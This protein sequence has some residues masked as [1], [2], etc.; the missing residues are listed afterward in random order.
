MIFGIQGQ[1]IARS[2]WTWIY[3]CPRNYCNV[4][5][6]T[7]LP[8]SCFSVSRN[9]LNYT[10]LSQRYASLLLQKV[11]KDSG[12]FL[13]NI[14]ADSLASINLEIASNTLDFR[15]IKQ[16]PL[17]NLSEDEAA[18]LLSLCGNQSCGK[19]TLKIRHA[20]KIFEGASRKTV[21]L[22]NHLL[23][24][25]I[26]NGKAFDSSILRSMKK[27]QLSPNAT[28]YAKLIG[29]HALQG[30]VD[31][32]QTIVDFARRHNMR[33]PDEIYGYIAYA[34][35]VSG[36]PN[37]GISMIDKFHEGGSSFSWDVSC[38]LLRGL[39][40]QPSSKLFETVLE[41][42]AASSETP[43][44][45]SHILDIFVN[46]SVNGNY[47]KIKPLLN[48]RK[49]SENEVGITRNTLVLNYSRTHSLNF[50]ECLLLPIESP[51]SGKN[52]LSTLFYT[53][54]L[55]CIYFS[56]WHDLVLDKIQKLSVVYPCTQVVHSL[57]FAVCQ[58][59]PW[60]LPEIL[61][62]LHDNDIHLEQSFKPPLDE[63]D[64][65]KMFWQ[66]VCL[67]QSVYS[68]QAEWTRWASRL[69]WVFA[70]EKNLKL[71][72]HNRITKHKKEMLANLKPQFSI[73]KIFMFFKAHGLYGW[74]F[75]D[76]QNFLQNRDAVNL[77]ETK[78]ASL[79]L[80]SDP[81]SDFLGD[82]V[83]NPGKL[84]A[85]SVSNL[86]T[87]FNF[88][89]S[90]KA[91]YIRRTS[92]LMF[93]KPYYLNNSIHSLSDRLIDLLYSSGSAKRCPILEMTARYLWLYSYILTP[94]C[95]LLFC[96]C[97]E[98]GRAA[99]ADKLLQ[100]LNFINVK[101]ETIPAFLLKSSNV[102]KLNV[103]KSYLEKRNSERSSLILLKSYVKAGMLTQACQVADT[104]SNM[105]LSKEDTHDLVLEF[106]QSENSVENVYNFVKCCHNIKAFNPEVFYL[107]A[108]R[109]FLDQN[110]FDEARTLALKFNSINEP[111]VVNLV[112]LS[113]FKSFQV[114]PQHVQPSHWKPCFQALEAE[115][116]DINEVL[117]HLRTANTIDKYLWIKPVF[118]SLCE[119]YRR[120]SVDDYDFVTEQVQSIFPSVQ[121]NRLSHILINQ[122]QKL[123]CDKGLNEAVQFACENL[124]ASSDENAATWSTV[125]RTCGDR[126]LA[127]N[128]SDLLHRLQDLTTTAVPK[129]KAIGDSY[130]LYCSM[131][132]SKS[133]ESLLELSADDLKQALPDLLELIGKNKD[134]K[135][136]N[137]LY[138]KLADRFQS[139]S[140]IHKTFCVSALLVNMHLKAVTNL[141]QEFLL[142]IA[143]ECYSATDDLAHLLR[144]DEYFR[145]L[146]F[147]DH[148]WHRHLNHYLFNRFSKTM[149]QTGVDDESLNYFV[150]MYHRIPSQDNTLFA[151]TVYLDLVTNVKYGCVAGNEL[152]VYH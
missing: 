133:F 63:N 78:I 120:I 101:I 46:L 65:P 36:F 111:A 134:E 13:S 67:A 71:K 119:L 70:I 76:L 19:R 102:E 81:K 79:R 80:I 103:V 132:Y 33:M 95:N 149:R 83:L 72:E 40:Q 26:E 22:F 141:S 32:A 21:N 41:K 151:R 91:A 128:D 126:A 139:D 53:L 142:E 54:F 108:L 148:L 55:N 112:C 3:L 131:K 11:R 31:G 77:D 127:S 122:V 144:T 66:S 107:T 150:R 87:R 93:E 114:P 6:K 116:F 110:R 69:R 30:D 85:S 37:E 64:F 123:A 48:C 16:I 60:L 98:H 97:L 25:Y 20:E 106:I 56:N 1:R 44:S 113:F 147:N 8:S 88:V 38:W 68:S 137:R 57:L 28:T 7:V 82:L 143:A 84:D 2:L 130:A 115:D 118:T 50:I 124:Q 129:V 125:I 35:C 105:N 29:G 59:R 75:G 5:N 121:P 136:L 92:Q 117:T 43:C 23:Q 58:E 14:K 24:S 4:S 73:E 51:L 94:V 104:G 39:A 9:R 27:L 61:K 52:T 47:D 10:S 15:T 86:K 89:P 99:E 146:P 138:G 12:K 42:F 34:L 145:S 140:E 135:T 74:S 62:L 45:L 109:M 18:F 49:F 96:F 152:C 100:K 17:S 90:N